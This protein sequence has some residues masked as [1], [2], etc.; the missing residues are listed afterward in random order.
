MAIFDELSIPPVTAGDDDFIGSEA[1]SDTV[2]Y[3]GLSATNGIEGVTVDLRNP[4]RQ[5]T[6]GSGNDLFE[7]IENL[8]GSAENDVFTGNADHNVLD[9]GGGDDILNGEAG[10]DT[11]LG[12]ADNDVLE[13]GDDTDLLNGGTGN[14]TASY[15]TAGGR[16]EV[17]LLSLDFQDTRGAGLDKLSSIENLI[18]SAFA[19]L[20]TGDDGNNTLDGRD[21]NDTLNGGGGVD[22]LNGDAGNDT[23]N[24]GTGND[25]LHGDDG[26][27]TLI[28]GL[29]DDLLDGGNDGSADTASYATATTSVVVDLT[30]QDGSTDQ[31]TGG[32]GR[33]T[34]LDIENLV[35]GAADDTLTGNDVNNRLSGGL[36]KDTLTGAAGLDT[37]LGGSGDDQLNGGLG[38]DV[39]NGNDGNDVLN[40]NEDHDSLTGSLGNDTLNGGTGDDVL[41]GDSGA[42]TLLGGSGNDVLNGGSNNDTIKG[43]AGND[44]LTGGSGSDSMTGGPGGFDIFD[45]NLAS[46]SGPGAT[47]RDVIT[48]FLGNGA[49]AGDQI[50]LR[51]IDANVGLGGNQ[52]FTFINGAAFSATNAAGQ[53]RYNSLT[54]LLQGSTDADTAAEFEISLTGNP[55]LS[56]S[57][58]ITRSDIL[59]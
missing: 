10:N 58:D 48:D 16:V 15:Q 40:G 24:G 6:G 46:E 17:S 34:L 36:G 52:A 43:D 7:S 55:S 19:D 57:A 32:A 53:L 21:G 18:G 44:T 9:G 39:L 59:L 35:G 14:D 37:L 25:F 33:D 26:S 8:T 2:D 27:D 45:F 4:D 41:N 22:T 11:L 51:D 23:L 29:G 54:G 1:E 3:S 47:A 42:D 20:L 38:N 5:N 12:G 30:V 13:G 49:S 31:D 50:D 56:V 28:G